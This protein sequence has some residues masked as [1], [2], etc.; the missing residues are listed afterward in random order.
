MIELAADYQIL[1]QSILG[2][3]ALSK[4][5]VHAHLGLIC[6]LLTALLFRR[7]LRWAPALVPG[8]LLSI[9]MEVMDLVHARAAGGGLAWGP[10]LHDLLNTNAPAVLTFVTARL[11]SVQKA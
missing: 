4:D 2:T 8:L 7:S 6:Y 9:G 11:L 3:L 5:A 10:T 1:K